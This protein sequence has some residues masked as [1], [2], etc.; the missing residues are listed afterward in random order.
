[1]FGCYLYFIVNVKELFRGII[2]KVQRVRDGN[3]LWVRKR[4]ADVWG[5]EVYNFAKALRADPPH[6]M[7]NYVTYNFLV[8]M[9][10]HQIEL[11]IYIQ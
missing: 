9:F 5:S 11:E 2:N 4:R 8:S 1:M 6:L 10:Y 3:S 7:S